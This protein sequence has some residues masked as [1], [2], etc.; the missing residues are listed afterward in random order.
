[1]HGKMRIIYVVVEASNNTALHPVSN[2]IP[3]CCIG[4]TF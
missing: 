1:M 2:K 3:E 4:D